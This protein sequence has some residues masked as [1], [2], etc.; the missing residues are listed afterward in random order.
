MEGVTSDLLLKKMKLQ[1][2]QILEKAG[3]LNWMEKNKPSLV[4]MAGAGD[5]D[6][7][8]LSVKELLA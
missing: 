5:I 6:A 1:D 4:V 3:L 2:K 7:L 8:V